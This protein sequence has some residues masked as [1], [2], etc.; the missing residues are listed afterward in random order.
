[1]RRQIFIFALVFSSLCFNVFAQGENTGQ[2]EFRDFQELSLED[3]LEIEV[4]TAAKKVQKISEAPAAMYVITDED[5][6]QSGATTIPDVLRMVPGL[7]VME[8]TASDFV[9]NAR[10]F[11]QEMSNK[12]LVLIDGRSVYW[13]FYGLVV[14]DSFPI[15]LEEIKRIEI[16]KGPGSALYGANAFS[17]VINILTK[18]PEEFKHRTSVSTAYGNLNTPQTSLIHSK[19]KNNLGY[20]LSLGWNRTQQW[21][22]PDRKEGEV[23]KLEATLRYRTNE[24]S[25]I[26]FSGGYNDG[27]GLTMTGIGRMNRPYN[28]T[29]LMLDYG[30]SGLGIRLFW[31]RVHADVLQQATGDRNFFDVDSYD[32]ESQYLF[33]MGSLNSVIFGG[34]YRLN[35]GQSD[36]IAKRFD[37]S[38]YAIYAQDEFRPVQNLAITLGIRYDGHSLFKDRITPRGNILVSPIKNHFL[39]FSYGTAFRNPSFLESY[40]YKDSDISDRVSLELP[41]NSVVV[42]ARGDPDLRPEKIASYEAGYEALLNDRIKCKLDLFYDQLKDF[43]SYEIVSYQDISYLLGLPLGAV[44]VPSEQS[45]LNEGRATAK[46]FE[47][48]LDV[49]V[50]NWLRGLANYSYQDITYEANNPVT[51]E[52]EKVQIIR[53]APRHKVNAALRFEPTSHLS[54]NLMMHHVSQ[55]ELKEDW[56]YGK[57]NPYTLFNIRLGYTVLD[58]IIETSL[59]VF[60]LLGNKHFEYPGYDKDG[61]P[62][63]GHQ[64]GR[65]VSF[66]L[67][68]NF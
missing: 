47:F 43:V 5:I 20:K 15:A 23:K 2:K 14:W 3:L 60:N 58:G 34:N 26:A 12:M 24:T 61:N 22:D 9:V 11:N 25:R 32:A 55:T 45:F 31:N 65:R 7:D 48:G 35:A 50:N 29:Y 66:G 51:P 49:L 63:A 41:S 38:L 8:I 39:R 17:G 67:L 64:I 40:L 52:N 1:M 53:T 13:D 62:C 28:W 16:V 57:V 68:L 44:V 10:G 46:G 30:G 21:N 33:S 19:T 59:S 42:E 6:R 18:T 4:V 54:A 37:Q 56:A 36:M 27:E